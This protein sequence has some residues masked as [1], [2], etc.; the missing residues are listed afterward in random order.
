MSQATIFQVLD[1]VVRESG[2]HPGEEWQVGAVTRAADGYELQY[3]RVATTEVVLRDED[4]RAV[5][6][7]LEGVIW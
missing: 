6:S 3:E 1:K 2:L 7:R 4:L 5:R